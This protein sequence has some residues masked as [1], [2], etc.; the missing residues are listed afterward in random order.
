[1]VAEQYIRHESD[2]R[3]VTGIIL[4]IANVYGPR[5]RTQGEGG[6]VAIFSEALAKGRV[7]FIEGDGEQTRDFVAATDVARAFCHNLG[8]A[9]RSATYNIG[10]QTAT[11]VNQLWETLATMAGLDVSAVGRVQSRAQDIRH[12]RLSISRA[13]D[14]GFHPLVV[15]T[16]GLEETYAWFRQTDENG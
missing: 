9:N 1:M 7:P 5:Q 13:T 8:Q 2:R 15:L 6:V 14:W 4:R 10:T 16:Q 3:R 12:S 11:S